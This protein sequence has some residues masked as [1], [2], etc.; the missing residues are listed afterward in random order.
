MRI[1][2]NNFIDTA[3][4]IA[5]T[6]ENADYPVENLQDQ[7]LGL[8]FQSTAASVTISLTESSISDN[9]VAVALLG[10]NLTHD[11]TVTF[12]LSEYSNFA[13]A[14]S[15][16]MTWNENMILKFIDYSG[17]ESELL[18]ESGGELWDESGGTLLVYYN[19]IY[20][21]FVISDATNPDGIIT[22]G[23]AWV[24]D[25]ITVSPSSLLDFKVTYKNSDVNIYGIH[26]TKFSVPGVVWRK[27]DM[28]FPPTDNAMIETIGAL[29]DQVGLHTSFIF[30]NFDSVRDYQ[31][32]EPCYVS[33]SGDIGFSHD[34]LDRFK[35]SLNLEEEL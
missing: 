12:Q 24:G 1:V 23:R 22:L 15:E 30:C 7:R 2:N 4:T 26:R 18:D 29:I 6:S 19:Y 9:P 25:Y 35:W 28:N 11:A 14:V 32:V 3:T 10:H 20:H 33:I 27:F 13:S 17:L 31:I 5:A 8:V 16:V 34:G 21:R